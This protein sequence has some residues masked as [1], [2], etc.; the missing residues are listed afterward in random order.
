MPQSWDTLRT[1][2]KYYL[3]NFGEEKQFEILEVLEN[4][5]FVVKD[6]LVLE[7]YH[8]SELVAYGKGDDYELFE[9]A[10]LN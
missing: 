2:K 6:L 4:G 9:L 7:T 3:K 8:L 10:K 1:G 5:D